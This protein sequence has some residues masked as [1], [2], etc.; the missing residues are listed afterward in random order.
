MP[1]AY[2][3]LGI[4]TDASDRAIKAAYR[5][6]AAEAHPDKGGDPER[7]LRIQAAFEVLR[8]PDRRA[9]HDRDPE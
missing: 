6:K 9:Q 1:S 3:V 7:F 2:E 8:D 4:A 5:K